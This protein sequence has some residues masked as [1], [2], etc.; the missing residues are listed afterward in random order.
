MDCIVHGATKSQTQ[1]SD[2]H[3]P[4]MKKTKVYNCV[5]FLEAEEIKVGKQQ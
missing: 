3:H 4:T 1:L 2:F 5:G